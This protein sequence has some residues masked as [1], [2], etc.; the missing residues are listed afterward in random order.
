VTQQHDEGMEE[1]AFIRGGLERVKA[2]R[3]DG[4]VFEAEELLN[5]LLLQAESVAGESS[6]LVG[7]VLME[8]LDFCQ[9][10]ERPDEAAL[11]WE[12]IRCVFQECSQAI[13]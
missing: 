11:V 10:N 1:D 5:E 9:K 13:Q 3:S 4:Q 12:R 8:L 7:L 2:L 6:A